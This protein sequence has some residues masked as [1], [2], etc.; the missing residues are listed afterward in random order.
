MIFTS[1][2]CVHESWSYV[3][4]KPA[5]ARCGRELPSGGICR[6]PLYKCKDCGNTGCMNKE[7]PNS[8]QDIMDK[9]KRCNS[10]SPPEKMDDDSE[11]RLS[12]IYIG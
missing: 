11:S 1:Y 7:C 6:S 5:T 8:L 12:K 2:R 9:C 4:A 10:S 3:P